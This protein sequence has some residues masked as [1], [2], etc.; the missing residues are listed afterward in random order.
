VPSEYL[1][2]LAGYAREF[3][4]LSTDEALLVERFRSLPASYRPLA[5]E[6]MASF[7]RVTASK[8]EPQPGG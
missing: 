3:P 4:E 5:L 8:L 1:R 2:E 6:L 7:G